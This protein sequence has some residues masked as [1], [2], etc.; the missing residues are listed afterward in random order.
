MRIRHIEELGFHN[1]FTA[2]RC[3]LAVADGQ[4]LAPAPLAAPL[5]RLLREELAEC[6]NGLAELLG[7]ADPDAATLAAGLAAALQGAIYRKPW[8]S[9]A[10]PPAQGQFGLF[11]EYTEPNLARLCLDTALRITGKLFEA[12]PEPGPEAEAVLGRILSAHRQ[13]QYE[14]TFHMNTREMLE[15]AEARGIP[16]RRIWSGTTHVQLGQGCKLK[17]FRGVMSDLDSIMGSELSHNKILAHRLL[18]G[19]GLPVPKAAQIASEDQ[20]I[21]MARRIGYPVVIKPNSLLKGIAV[22]VNLNTEQEVRQA[23]AKAA[24]HGRGVN[25]ESMIAGDDHRILVVAGR[26][27]AV[28]RREPAKV[29]GDGK[30]SLRELI[31][32]E[33]ANPLRLPS[34]FDMLSPIEPDEETERLLARLGLTLDSVPAAGRIV[35]LKATAN[36]ASG[37]TATDFTDSIHPDNIA[38]AER[39]ARLVDIDVAGIDY[40]TTDISRSYRETGGAI[41][42]V[43]TWVSLAPHRAAEP[44]R[45]VIPAIMNRAFA[46]GDDGRIP[47]AAIS[48]SGDHAGIVH[49]LA[50]I[51]NGAGLACG[52]TTDK[53]ARV[54][55]EIVMRGNLASYRGAEIVLADPLCAA[56]ALTLDPT[57]IAKRGLAFDR[58][59][60]AGLFGLGEIGDENRNAALRLLAAVEEAV[61]LR[62]ADAE[63]LRQAG[64]LE[65]RRLILVAP[66]GLDPAAFRH[67]ETGGEAVLAETGSGGETLLVYREGEAQKVL[68]PASRLSRREDMPRPELLASALAA[69]ALALGLGQTLSAIAAGLE[70]EAEEERLA[71]S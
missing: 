41:C 5:T 39:A 34:K 21:A 6:G 11:L 51:L 43:N 62:T 1:R 2:G 36:I 31:A 58:C 57:D 15:E 17:R 61:V 45:N 48:G 14:V 32:A 7:Q 46:A 12:G 16:W 35:P 18:A 30:S 38:M 54:A 52:D 22:F 27:V 20:A 53:E 29:T 68:L 50:R 44:P 33:N 66:Q 9:G 47:I 60:V 4:Q 19:G 56:A 59:T 13:R 24:A 71:F 23:Y 55:G 28:S 63:P 64:H 65:G 26:F 70:A 37:A 8:R 49:S 3:L 67:L 10:L 42:E 40:I 69:A 25:I